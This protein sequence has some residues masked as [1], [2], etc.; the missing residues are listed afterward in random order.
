MTGYS[1]AIGSTLWYQTQ[2]AGRPF[3]TVAAENNGH[4]DGLGTSTSHVTP[5][6]GAGIQVD[7]AMYDLKIMFETAETFDGTRDE[8]AAISLG[9]D[10]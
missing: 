1:G 4:D 9:F 8:S 10:F 5:R 7:G 6:I 2:G 3:L